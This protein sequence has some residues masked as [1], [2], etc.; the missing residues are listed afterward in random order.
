MNSGLVLE[1]L[2]CFCCREKEELS[3][4]MYTEDRPQSEAAP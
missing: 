4:K 2:Y 3:M 1:T